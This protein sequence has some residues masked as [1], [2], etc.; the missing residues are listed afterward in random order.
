MLSGVTW[1]PERQRQVPGQGNAQ[2]HPRQTVGSTLPLCLINPA[3]HSRCDRPC[4]SLALSAVPVLQYMP[5]Y[6]GTLGPWPAGDV[7]TLPA[8]PLTTRYRTR[9]SC[10]LPH[11]GSLLFDPDTATSRVD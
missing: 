11:S 7:L 3:P 6:L 1:P 5:R 9:S 2:V 4:V 10:L 8:F